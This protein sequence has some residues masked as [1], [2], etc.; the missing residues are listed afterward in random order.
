MFVLA[1][2]LTITS[3]KETRAQTD[4]T[5]KNQYLQNHLEVFEVKALLKIFPSGAWYLLSPEQECS[6]I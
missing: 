2:N 3:I 6:S 4:E 5:K 1:I